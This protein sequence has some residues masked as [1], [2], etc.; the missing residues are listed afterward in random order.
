M[1]KK[2]EIKSLLILSLNGLI[3]Q[4]KLKVHQGEF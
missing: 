2:I 4:T 3:Y 1:I